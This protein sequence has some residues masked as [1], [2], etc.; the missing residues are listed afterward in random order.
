[1]RRVRRGYLRATW[2]RQAELFMAIVLTAVTFTLLAENAVVSTVVLRGPDWDSARLSSYDILVRPAGTRSP[3]EQS[4]GLVRT[5]DVTSLSGGITL[6]QY[7]AIA[8]LPGVR[9]AAPMTMVGYVL[10]TVTLPVAVPAAA[11]RHTPALFVAGLT[12]TTDQG[13]TAITQPGAAYT[14]LTSNRLQTVT[15][16]GQ[17]D[18]PYG[19]YE[20]APGGSRLVCPFQARAP[21][22]ADPFAARATS[23]GTCW[24]TQDGAHGGGWTS[25]P[26]RTVAVQLRWTFP[27]LLAAIDPTAEAR[28]LGLDHALAGGDYLPTTPTAPGAPI[29]ILLANRLDDD[30]QD[31]VRLTQLPDSA[32]NAYR[33]GL[34][35]D[36]IDHLLAQTPG[37]P[38]GTV[39]VDAATAYQQLLQQRIGSTAPDVVSAYWTTAPPTYGTNPDGSITPRPSSADATQPW[40][41]PQ[42]P[43]GLAEAPPDAADT[44]FAPLIPH[45][46]APAGANPAPRLRTVGVF[47]P[48]AVGARG[49]ASRTYRADTLPAADARSAALLGGGSL[50]HNANPAG[51]P[52]AG[53][54]MLMSLADIAAFSSPA[55]FSNTNLKAPIGSIRI[56]V[57]GVTGVDPASRERVRAVADRIEQTAH[58]DIDVLAGDT[59]VQRVVVLPANGHGRPALRLTETWLRRDT[60]TMITRLL[61]R[62]ATGLLTVLFVVGV[63]LLGNAWSASFA[64]RGATLA[65]L[66]ELHWRARHIARLLAGEV[67]L[68][69]TCAGTVAAGIA[70]LATA[71]LGAPVR[72]L[73]S[74]LAIPAALLLA[75]AAATGPAWRAT[76]HATAPAREPKASTRALTAPAAPRR[77]VARGLPHLAGVR[78]ARTPVRTGLSVLAVALAM[79]T[80]TGQVAVGWAFGGD[81]VGTLLGVVVS[82][83][84]RGTDLATALASVVVSGLALADMARLN[85][86][87]RPAELATLRMTGWSISALTNLILGEAAAVGA[88]GGLLA[89]GTDLALTAATVHYVPGRVWLLSV[90]TVVA[91]TTLA[92]GAAATQCALLRRTLTTLPEPASAP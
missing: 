60:T 18:S 39:V 44:G 36:Q 41:V 78:A 30:D 83:Q 31:T 73:P 53:P 5:Q 62:T 92:I 16:P 3:A 67:V 58:L 86:R 50:Q 10:Q 15:H 19:V 69:A 47:D 87:E 51:Y 54:A 43:A 23:R 32:A 64:S 6:S 46:A 29:P 55:T 66:H 49:L 56:Q 70:V 2:R 85:L 90:A 91:A 4:A 81:F 82:A 42:A 9:V 75:L 45:V 72:Y 89:A 17:G 27:V 52:A 76:R 48:T 26:G 25:D 34:T 11:V 68:L 37:R 61:D 63:L 40:I 65:T 88:T 38:I 80:L 35:S 33:T 20:T 8:H 7:Q 71:L 1:M 28:L 84:A 21:D 22:L 14:Y 13:L 12:R 77:P 24:S 74:L 57:D 59:A 79:A